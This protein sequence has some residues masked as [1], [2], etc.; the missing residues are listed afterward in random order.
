MQYI[1]FHE[2]GTA[3]DFLRN[4]TL[5][6]CYMNNEASHDDISFVSI[7]LKATGVAW[8]LILSGGEVDALR[9]GNYGG[10]GYSAKCAV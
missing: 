5:V 2:R 3:C 4:V 8:L 7:R 9:L 1:W 6:E 10:C